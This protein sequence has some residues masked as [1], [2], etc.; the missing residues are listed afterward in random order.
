[1]AAEPKA[2]AFVLYGSWGI[3][4]GVCS[5]AVTSPADRPT[6]FTC[7]VCDETMPV[8][9][10]AEAAEIEAVLSLRPNRANRHWLPHE[11]VDELYVENIE[12]GIG[13]DVPKRRQPM[14]NMILE[15]KRELD[16]NHVI[17]PGTIVHRD[18]ELHPAKIIEYLRDCGRN[19]SETQAQR[20]L[21]VYGRGFQ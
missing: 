8:D 6:R 7:P 11:A 20:F 13:G 19:I 18:S 14:V 5:S 2:Q 15:A 4:C 1:M 12:H 17:A 10:P 9:W 21:Y 16:P 3:S